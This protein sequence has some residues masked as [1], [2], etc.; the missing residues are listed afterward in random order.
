MRKS[1]SINPEEC[2]KCKLKK[3]NICDGFHPCGELMTKT[4]CTEMKKLGKG[5]DD[6]DKV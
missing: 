1:K 6:G 4:E 5:E 3:N 2:K